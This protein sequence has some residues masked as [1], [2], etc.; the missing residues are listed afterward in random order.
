MIL[1]VRRIF[2]IART[3]LLTALF[4]FL[5]VYCASGISA[6]FQAYFEAASVFFSSRL[7]SFFFK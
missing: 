2:R 4:F 5:L 3:S 1:Y 7:P 6:F